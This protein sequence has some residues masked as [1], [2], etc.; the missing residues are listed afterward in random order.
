MQRFKQIFAVERFYVDSVS[1]LILTSGIKAISE[2]FY[3]L[4]ELKHRMKLSVLA[5]ITVAEQ[6]D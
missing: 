2:M 5:Q 4:G 6:V 1:H 3:E